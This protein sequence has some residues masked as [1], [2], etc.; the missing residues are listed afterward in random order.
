LTK[1]QNILSQSAEKGGQVIG[2]V[3]DRTGN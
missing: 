1:N 3:L 2:K